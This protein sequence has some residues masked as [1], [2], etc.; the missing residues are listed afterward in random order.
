[1]NRPQAPITHD[2]SDGHVVPQVPQLASSVDVSMHV[3]AHATRPAAQQRP[4]V[5]DSPATHAESHMPQCEASVVVST[6]TSPQRVGVATSHGGVHVP[7]SQT[8]PD[9]QATSH[10]PQ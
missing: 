3:P 4:S 8:E 9:A 2:S 10:I 1:V 6:Q 5:Q 7:I